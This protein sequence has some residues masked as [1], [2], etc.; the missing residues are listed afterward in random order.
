MAMVKPP[1]GSGV[2]PR[3]PPS[4]HCDHERFELRQRVYA[5]GTRH[6]L[7]QCVR[8]GASGQSLKRDAVRTIA[9]WATAPAFAG[10]WSA[11]FWA[12]KDA[13]RRAEMDRQRE[14]RQAEYAEYLRSPEWRQRRAARLYLDGWRCQARL[15]GCTDRATEVHHLTYQHVGNEPLF[16]LV[17]VCGPCHR[18][19]TEMDRQEYAS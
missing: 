4:R 14:E 11:R 1:D 19:I 16:D 5:N 15:S 10:A 18:T 12:E 6:F 2:D 3:L 17:S 7:Y 13:Q 9:G 8:C